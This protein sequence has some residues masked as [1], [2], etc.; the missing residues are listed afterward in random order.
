[1]GERDRIPRQSLSTFQTRVCITTAVCVFSYCRSLCS[2]FATCLSPK[3]SSSIYMY[4]RAIHLY[5]KLMAGNIRCSSIRDGDF[6]PK[7][8][9]VISNSCCIFAANHGSQSNRLNESSKI[10][11]RQVDRVVNKIRRR[12]SL[13]TTS[14][15]VDASWPFATR[16]SINRTAP[17]P[18]L[19]FVLDLLCGS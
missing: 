1:M 14:T 19:R 5:G 12:S 13:L 9:S 17:T 10:S 3:Y 2:P 16:R 18:L 15:T 4:V 11:P 7:R 6:Y 8:T